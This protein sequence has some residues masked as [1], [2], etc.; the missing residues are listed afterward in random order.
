MFEFTE[1][2]NAIFYDNKEFIQGSLFKNFEEQQKEIQESEN[3]KKGV[4]V[5]LENIYKDTSKLT[6]IK[7][8]FLKYRK[9][10][11]SFLEIHAFV[12]FTNEQFLKFINTYFTNNDI[13]FYLKLIE[14]YDDF[15]SVYH[16][17]GKVF[18]FYLDTFVY[19]KNIAFD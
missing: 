5:F 1:Y 6:A 14:K 16:Q 9:R 12:L 3:S 10:G 8:E 2:E 13:F 7:D 17:M 11:L 19:E 15:K 18:L 4:S